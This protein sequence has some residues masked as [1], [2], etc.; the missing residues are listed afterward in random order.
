MIRHNYITTY[1]SGPYDIK[2]LIGE[3]VIENHLK[4]TYSDESTYL[5]A[6]VAAAW[7]RVEVHLGIRYA[8][9]TLSW[10]AQKCTDKIQLPVAA[11]RIDGDVSVQYW[12]GTQY[13]DAVLVYRS[14]LGYPTSVTIDRDDEAFSDFDYDGEAITMKASCTVTE[15]TPPAA[16]QQAFLLYLGYLYEKREAVITGTIATELPR[17]YEY[18]LNGYRVNNRIR[19]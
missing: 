7:D 12:D 19:F 1:T 3:D 6:L 11:D 17:A 15:L 9:S 10:E 14:N 5:D 4:V 8:A 18:L 2:T 16:V 13:N